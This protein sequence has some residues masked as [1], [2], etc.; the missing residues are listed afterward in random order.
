MVLSGGLNKSLDSRTVA[1]DITNTWPVAAS[2]LTDL[3]SQTYYMVCV[4]SK[5]SGSKMLS[6][7]LHAPV[8]KEQSLY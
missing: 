4:I 8:Y 5:D 7:V 3:P 2:P 1:L 6:N